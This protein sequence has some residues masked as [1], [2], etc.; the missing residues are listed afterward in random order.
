MEQ[1]YSDFYENF[2]VIKIPANSIGRGYPSVLITNI[3]ISI[4]TVQYTTFLDYTVHLITTSG[5]KNNLNAKQLPQKNPKIFDAEKYS[6]RSL[7][8]I[9]KY[10]IQLKILNSNNLTMKI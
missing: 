5:E 4:C 9:K 3:K 7:T 1:I 10:Y 8:R 2:Q 6:T